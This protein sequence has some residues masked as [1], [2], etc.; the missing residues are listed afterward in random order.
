MAGMGMSQMTAKWR[1]S[2]L[3][4]SLVLLAACS[5]GE[6]ARNGM[7]APLADSVL[8]RSL[9]RQTCLRIAKEPPLIEE[10]EIHCVARVGDTLAGVITSA[11]N[12]HVK[13]V[14][15]TWGDTLKP[16]SGVDTIFV[17]KLTAHFG[18]SSAYPGSASGRRWMLTN[19]YLIL[20][21]TRKGSEQQVIFASQES[22]RPASLPS[23]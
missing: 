23:R 8:P 11:V 7:L 16:G 9:A 10:D 2:A 3:V 1:G 18:P 13:R 17:R 22:I 5:A 20:V 19:G 4:P 6:D 14:S 21:E 12:G 15:R